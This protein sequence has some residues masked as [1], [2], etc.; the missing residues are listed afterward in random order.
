MSLSTA[1]SNALTGLTANSRAAGVVSSNLANLST[2][3]YGRRDIELSP[4]ARGGA[5]GV[6]VI[7]ITR[8]VDQGL[9]SDRRL[10]DSAL[11]YAD[12]RARF[13]GQVQQAVGTPDVPGSL[14]SRIAAFESSLTTAASRPEAPERLQAVA[15]RAA[16]LVQGFETISDEIQG[17][18]QSAEED[19]A[20]VVKTLN[21]ALK[22]AQGLNAEITD[23]R[24]RG[25]DVSSLEDHRQV[26]IDRIA[27]I[28]PVRELPRG[29][30]EIALVT[31]GG[32]LLLDRVPVEFEFTRANMIVPDM[33]L[34]NGGLSGIQINGLDVAPAGAGSPLNGGRLA[35]LFE[36]R[37]TLATDAQTQLDALT[38]DMV[39]RFQQPGLDPSLSA[40]DAGLFTDEGTRFDPVDEV[41]LAGRLTLN[42]LVD[43][44]AGGEVWRLR[45]G[46][47]AVAQ[48]PT[49]N[50]DLL[51]AFSD[52]LSGDRVLASGGLG[53]GAGSVAEHAGGLASYVGQLRLTGDQA[54][55][56]A[57]TRQTELENMLLQGGVDSDAEA[58]RLLII[59][60]AF[61]ANARM[62]Q[63]L[64]DMMQ[65]L[66]RL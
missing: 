59:E 37:D 66:L 27:E 50:S 5:G 3:G 63:T 44:A 26:V 15:A 12:T 41:G 7:A 22:Q 23:A 21:T 62:I 16:E 30:G 17:R 19:I 6:R 10:A 2:P 9:L 32:A 45:D 4:I 13:L 53:T 14:S 56:F 54:T 38:R 34:A 20:F 46:L 40:A 49:G 25:F 65:T 51:L 35:A 48:G 24:R 57:V 47:G 60:Q 28:V 64:D 8:N 58:Q 52:A 43:P 42:A 55:S 33:T 11:S 29:N 36:V 61:T 39:E 31:T 1:L 18:R